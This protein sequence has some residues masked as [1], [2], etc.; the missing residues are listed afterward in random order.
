MVPSLR[1]RISQWQ[2]QWLAP[3]RSAA[4]GG[5]CGCLLSGARSR[6]NATGPRLGCLSY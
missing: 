5:R 4:R 3:A 2:H 1:Y 6:A